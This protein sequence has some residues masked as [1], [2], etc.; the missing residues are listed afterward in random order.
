MSNLVTVSVTVPADSIDKLYQFAASLNVPRHD[1][2]ER[3]SWTEGVGIVWDAGSVM[4]NVIQDARWLVSLAIDLGYSSIPYELIKRYEPGLTEQKVRD[5]FRSLNLSGYGFGRTWV[6][7][8]KDDTAVFAPGFLDA[9]TRSL[10]DGSV[11]QIL[12]DSVSPAQF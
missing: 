4:R 12:A 5:A 2:A 9:V 10:P 3:Q 8:M 6:G 11:R 7:H 1:S